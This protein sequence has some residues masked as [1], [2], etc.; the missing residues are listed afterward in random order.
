MSRGRVK[1]QLAYR[2]QPDRYG[3]IPEK[4]VAQYG[5]LTVEVEPFDMGGGVDCWD[6]MACSEGI[7]LIDGAQFEGRD[8]A[9]LYAETLV[10]VFNQKN[11]QTLAAVREK[12]WFAETQRQV[13]ERR[14]YEE[15]AAKR[16]AARDRKKAR[17][18]AKVV[19]VSQSES[20]PVSS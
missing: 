2:G 17:D 16:K 7:E 10:R 18:A 14:A 5:H 11:L 20:A 9:I 19:G 4:W 1:W 12:L 3:R 6:V 13:E 8:D 15:R